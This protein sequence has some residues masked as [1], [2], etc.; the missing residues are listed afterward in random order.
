MNAAISVNLDHLRPW[1]PWALHE[2]IGEDKRIEW[3]RTQRGHFDLGG[4]Y[5]FG[6]FNKDES[7]MLGGT[8]LKMVG[9]PDER[10]IGYWIDVAHLQQ[11]LATE[12][13]AA[14]I[15]IGFELE[16]LSTITIRVLPD[17]LPSARVPEKLGFSG[18]VLEPSSLPWP[19][20]GKRDGYA[21]ALSRA[22]YVASPARQA[23]IEAYDVLDRPLSLSPV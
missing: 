3:L 14:L 22:Q 23:K 11:G 6:I 2:P 17:N 9:D 16:Q 4:D 10:E 13:S 1:M 5:F 12:I 21:Y 19:G 8:G 7:R 18:P 15:R 20:E